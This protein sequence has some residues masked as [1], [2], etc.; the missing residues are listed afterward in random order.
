MEATEKLTFLNLQDALKFKKATF[1]SNLNEMSP[2][3][4]VFLT[5][6]SSLRSLSV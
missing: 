3:S 5:L 4:L 2:F 1:R 6:I